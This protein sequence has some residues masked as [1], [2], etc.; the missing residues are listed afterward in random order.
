MS[1]KGFNDGDKAVIFNDTKS[2]STKPGE[3]F[4]KDSPLS[5]QH[6]ASH[7]VDHFQIPELKEAEEWFSIFDTS[8]DDFADA[9]FAEGKNSFRNSTEKR[10]YVAAEIRA[11]TGQLKDFIAQ[12]KGIPLNKDFKVTMKDLENA[13]ENYVKEI[14]DING[15]DKITGSVKDKKKLLQLMNKYALS[16]TSL[17][18]I[19]GFSEGTDKKAYGGKVDFKPFILHGGTI[20]N[21]DM[22]KTKKVTRKKAAF[23]MVQLQADKIPDK[24][25]V[26]RFNDIVA[27]KRFIYDEAEKFGLDKYSSYGINDGEKAIIFND[28]KY[29]KKGEGFTDTPLLERGYAASHEVDHFYRNSSEEAEKW[30]S[31]FDK[32]SDDWVKMLWGD[33]V[34]TSGHSK[35]AIRKEVSNELRARAGQL[36]DFIAARQGIP[37]DKDFKIT[38]SSLEDGLENYYKIDANRSFMKD[39]A[40]SV[41]DK[42]KLLEVMN[43]VALGLP[44]LTI[45][46]NRINDERLKEEPE[47]KAFGGTINNTDMK[48]TKKVTRKKAAFGMVQP[49]ADTRAAYQQMSPVEALA[50]NKLNW[51]KA[52]GHVE[53]EKQE[54]QQ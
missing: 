10:M 21:T 13:L 26:E 5:V 14:G 32:N 3:L 51:D 22:K 37:F 28:S 23:G 46:G 34:N 42:K 47:S 39:F 49:Q 11:R 33:N 6:T 45:F 16:A 30:L 12:R 54:H 19:Y 35:E 31:L 20:N 18:A 8:I 53:N 2:F 15:T 9:F 29:F 7:E 1:T 43:N 36:K 44:P 27:R 38:M 4:K 40:E 24:S 48:K 41:K 25:M 50:A 17:G 52:E